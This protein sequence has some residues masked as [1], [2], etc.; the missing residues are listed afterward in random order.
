MSCSV[1]ML[2]VHTSPLDSP[3][4]T[5]DAGGMNVYM[6]E[7]ACALAKYN[8]KVDIFTRWTNEAIPQVVQLVPNVR[9]IHVK[10]GPVAPIHKNDLYQ[11]LP[12]FTRHIEEFCCRE[13][14]SYDIIHSH[15]WLSGVAALRLAKLWD[16]PHVTTFHTLARL[17]QLANP[18]EPESPI[19]LEMEQ[20]LI[21]QVDRI[22][23]PTVDERTELIRFCGARA[24]QVEVVP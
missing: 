4:R 3:G 11:Y 12:I 8:I 20:R 2:S 14:R 1:A 24:S 17:K 21:Q 5:K 13:A 15:Y 23:A 7:L 9:V 10:A 22:I 19:R 6:R 16:I 18:G